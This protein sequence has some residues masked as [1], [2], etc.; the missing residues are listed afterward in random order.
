[1]REDHIRKKAKQN[2]G[3]KMRNRKMMSIGK[4]QDVENSNVRKMINPAGSFNPTGGLMAA[5]KF[6]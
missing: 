1:M 3:S 2:M 6:G 5:R 4:L